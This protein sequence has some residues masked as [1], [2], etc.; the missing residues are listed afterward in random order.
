VLFYHLAF[1]WKLV[2][3]HIYIIYVFRFSVLLWKLI[4]DTSIV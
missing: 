2:I 3:H 1:L 4:K